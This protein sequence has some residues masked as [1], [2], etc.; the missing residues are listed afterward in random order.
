MIEKLLDKLTE[1][2]LERLEP[3]IDA[4]SPYAQVIIFGDDLGMQNN[5]LISP[6]MYREL[7]F[8]RHKEIFKYVKNKSNLHTFLHSCGAISNLMPD[9]IEA[10]LDII[11][12]V[13]INA[14]GMESEKLKREFGKDLVFWGG[15]V[16]TQ[17]TLFYATEQK[18]RDEVRKNCEI[19]M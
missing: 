10:G 14:T 15:G 9:L 11:N 18:I 6:A 13:Q 7:F 16:D 5:S 3:F 2:H 4:V 12:P 8:P 17:H 19:F 1:I